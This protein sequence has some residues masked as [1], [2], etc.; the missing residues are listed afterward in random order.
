MQSQSRTL[1]SCSILRVVEEVGAAIQDRR[2]VA[3]PAGEVAAVVA[4][5]VA[6]VV[7]R[8]AAAAV[9]REVVAALP[10]LA[11][12]LPPAITIPIINPARSSLPS[13]PA[14]ATTNGCFTRL[15]MGPVA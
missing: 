12:C 4:K 14:P 6:A 5:E 11:V 1:F 7:A 3:H 10:A 2:G 15:P 9:A 8:E 13:L